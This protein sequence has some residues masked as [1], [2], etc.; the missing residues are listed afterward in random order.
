MEACQTNETSK[1]TRESAVFSP[2]PA[3]FAQPRNLPVL[4]LP[5]GSNSP[6]RRC[7]GGFSERTKTLFN[8]FQQKDLGSVYH[9]LLCGA[10]PPP[11]PGRGLPPRPPGAFSSPTSR[12]SHLAAKPHKSSR[13]VP[14]AQGDAGVC[15]QVQTGPKNRELR[16]QITGGMYPAFPE[17]AAGL[18]FRPATAPVK[19]PSH[20]S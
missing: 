15:R 20:R 12:S 11:V 17:S 16:A 13:L 8:A 19:P 3:L 2:N 9:F 18:R 7:R 14:G 10:A 6:P 5:D 1:S 4:Q